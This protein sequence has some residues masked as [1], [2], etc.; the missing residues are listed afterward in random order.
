MEMGT[1]PG[2]P[3]RG[4]EA[5]GQGHGRL[6]DRAEGSGAGDRELKSGHWG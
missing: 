1:G 4:L 3:D 5:E 6:G 2:D